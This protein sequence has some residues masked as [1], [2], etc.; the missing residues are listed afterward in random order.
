[1]SF[2]IYVYDGR[3]ENFLHKLSM[4]C[5]PRTGEIIFMFGLDFEVYQVIYEKFETLESRI[6][7][8]AIRKEKYEEQISEAENESEEQNQENCQAQSQV[9]Q[10]GGR[11]G[12]SSEEDKESRSKK[13]TK[14]QLRAARIIIFFLWICLIVTLISIFNPRIENICP[15]QDTPQLVPGTADPKSQDDEPEILP[16]PPSKGIYL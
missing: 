14:G 3:T 2:E 9:G 15:A 10:A 11:S 16:P 13:F 6:I 1:M 7:I 12:S 8:Y 4:P 5:V